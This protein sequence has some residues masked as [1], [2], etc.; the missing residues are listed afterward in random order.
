MDETE[1]IDLSLLCNLVIYP[2]N[3]KMRFQREIKVLEARQRLE[4]L[5]VP[6][7]QAL[8][9]HQGLLAP[10]AGSCCTLLSWLF[11]SSSER[12]SS[13]CLGIH[14]SFL[15]A[16]L[17]QSPCRCFV[18][19]SRQVRLIFSAAGHAIQFSESQQHFCCRTV[20]IATAAH[21]GITGQTFSA[22]FI[23][24]LFDQYT[25]V[26]A[27]VFHCGVARTLLP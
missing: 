9:R 14:C 24:M 16:T 22:P 15:S 18:V 20:T 21:T 6:K 27:E 12:V 13:G 23:G 11:Q 7:R 10:S 2:I 1:R 3:L 25:A 17:P 5:V 26:S 4:A 19:L 8:T